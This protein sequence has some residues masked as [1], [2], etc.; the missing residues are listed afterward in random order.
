MTAFSSTSDQSTSVA[1]PSDGFDEDA[2]ANWDAPAPAADEDPVAQPAPPARAP[3]RAA[4]AKASR[5]APARGGSAATAVRRAAAK[6]LEIE[7]APDSQRSLLAQLLNV[8]DD[9]VELT[10]AVIAGA[11]DAGSKYLYAIADADPI[12][13]GATAYAVV[14]DKE[15]AKALW[16]LLL[17]LGAVTGDKPNVPV[18]AARTIA[19]AAQGLSSD[20]RSTLDSALA[21]AK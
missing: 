13:A 3:R 19:R 20:A 5:P 6:A 18:E 14:E 9:T 16:A 15:R 8:R 2:Q 12:D 21:L 7:S 11:P 10:V 17:A 1:D 4:A